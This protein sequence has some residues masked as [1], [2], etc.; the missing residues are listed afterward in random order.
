MRL[1]IRGILCLTL[2]APVCLVWAGDEPTV[3]VRY[4]G[5]RTRTASWECTPGHTVE[6][7]D[8]SLE[9]STIRYAFAYSGCTDPSHGDKRPSSE[10]NFGMTAPV[11]GNYYAGGFLQVFI[12]GQDAIAYRVE[13]MQVLEQGARGSFQA[14]FAHPDAEVGLRIALLPESNHILMLVSWRP[15]PDKAV[16]SVRVTLRAYPSFF[17]S[18]HHRQGERHCATPRTDQQEPS[19]LE[20]VPE[21]DGYL[22]FY[23]AVFDVA[24]GEGD[25]PCAAVISPEGLTGGR[26]SIQSYPVT[27]SLD[28]APEAAEARLALYDFAGLTNAQAQQYLDDNWQRDQAEL[29]ALDFR[30]EAARTLDLA[31]FEQQ[32]HKLLAEAAA[33][34]EALRPKVEE[35]LGKL[36]QAQ[37]QAAAGDWQAEAQFSSLLRDSE[38]LLWKLRI[39][40]LLNREV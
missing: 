18:F 25:G 31:A 9:S 38:A 37:A 34:G 30:P 5:V 40:A 39:F 32:T 17:T 13:D 33:D 3:S 16:Q 14:I 28:Y 21:E 29:M 10:G 1:P 26:V 6:T 22:H 35:L 23:D 36:N 27:T 4:G 8:I 15:R 7:R 12:N 20:I 19:T 2:L 24:N 11:R